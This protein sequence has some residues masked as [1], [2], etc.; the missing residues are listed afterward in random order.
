M[1]TES[2]IA[3]V[4]ARP[5]GSIVTIVMAAPGWTL[6]DACAVTVAKRAELADLSWVDVDIA[7]WRRVRQPRR[8]DAE[9]KLMPPVQ[10]GPK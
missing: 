3:R 9:L 1:G 8:V 5:D 10:R 6:D 7:T 2:V 4:Y